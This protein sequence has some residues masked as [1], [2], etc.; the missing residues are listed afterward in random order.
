[1]FR[2]PTGQAEEMTIVDYHDTWLARKN[3]RDHEATVQ[4]QAIQ[5]RT[6]SHEAV[7]TGLTYNTLEQYTLDQ[8][9]SII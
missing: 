6:I 1:V 2:L 8:L 7:F 3:A 9:E 4:I 5:L